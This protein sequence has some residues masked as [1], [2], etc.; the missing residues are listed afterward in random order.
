LAGQ[1][2]NVGRLSLVEN[3]KPFSTLLGMEAPTELCVG[4]GIVHGA[5]VLMLVNLNREYKERQR[6][7]DGHDRAERRE[8]K[9]YGNSDCDEDIEKIPIENPPG[10]GKSLHEGLSGRVAQP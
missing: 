7:E 1:P 10:E 2:V 8:R 6:P 5:F 4:T 3:P 9:W